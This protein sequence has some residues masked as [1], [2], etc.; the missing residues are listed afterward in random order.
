MRTIM[1]GRDARGPNMTRYFFS[2]FHNAS[3]GV[4]K[5]PLTLWLMPSK[6]GVKII[7][8]GAMVATA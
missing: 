2:T 6:Q 1:S 3:D 5:R 7:A 8:V 4:L